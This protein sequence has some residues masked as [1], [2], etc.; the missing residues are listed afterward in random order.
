MLISWI[1]VP[2]QAGYLLDFPHTT[3]NNIDCFNCHNV[4]G[5]MEKFFNVVMPD[6]PQNLDDTPANNLCWSCHNDVVAPFMKTHSSI[7]I[8][9]DYGDWAIECRTCHEPHYHYQLAAY[10]E[11]AHLTSGVITEVTET[12]LTSAG[13][14]WQDDEFAGLV[15]LIRSV[16]GYR[17]VSNTSDTLT[18]K[19][20]VE[21]DKVSPGDNFVVIY[22]KLVRQKINTPNSGQKPV[23][24]FRPVGPNSLVDGDDVYNGPCEVCHTKTRHHRNNNNNPEQADHTHNVGIKCTLC[25]KHVNGFMPLGAGAHDI[26]LVKDFG[27][28]ITCGEGNWGCHGSYEPGSNYPNEVYFADGL[29][30]CDSRPNTACPNAGADTGTQV[31]A[32]CHGEGSLL[33]KYYFFRPGSSEGESGIKVTAYSGEYTWANTW[34]G[35]LGEQKFCGS[36]HNDS[37]NPAPVAGPGSIGDPPNIVGDLNLETGAN[38]YGFYVNGHGKP[39]DQNYGRLSWQDSGATGNPGAGRVCSDCHDYTKGHWDTGGTKRLKEGYENDTNNSV[40]VQCHGP[41][42]LADANPRWF[43][44]YATYDNSA[45]GADDKQ[46]IQCSTC[47][48]PHG[49]MDPRNP[50]AGSAATA[51]TRGNK[52]ELCFRCHSDSGDLMHV[53]NFAIDGFRGTH[54]GI[55]NQAA[56]NDA[57]GL[58]YDY[59][60]LMDDPDNKYD[61][62][63]TWTVFN[64]TDGSS[65]VIYAPDPATDRTIVTATLTGGTD[66]DWDVGDEYHIV[67]NSNDGEPMD[68]IEKAFSYPNATVPKGDYDG[69]GAQHNMG[70]AFVHD[71]KNYN[72]QC[73]SCHNVHLVTG[74]FWEADKGKSPVSKFPPVNDVPEAI[75]G[76]DPGEKMDVFAASGDGIYRPT[77]GDGFSGDQLPAYPQFCLGC[78]GQPQ[79]NHERFGI[80]WSADPSTAAGDMHGLETAGGPAGYGVCPNWYGCGKA[81]GWGLDE[82]ISESPEQE[83]WPV[84]PRGRGDEIHSRKNYN[85]EERVAGANFVLSCT[86]C[87]EAHGS[88]NVSMLRPKTNL[89]TGDYAWNTMCNNCHYY[90]SD[91]HAGMSCGQSSCHAAR[92]PHRMVN[93]FRGR[94]NNIR[95][96]DSDLVLNLSFNGNL[97][98]SSNFLLDSI[99]SMDRHNPAVSR[100]ACKGA[101]DPYACCT[102]P[103]IGTCNAECT[104]DGTPYSCCTS[105]ER[106]MCTDDNPRDVCTDYDNPDKVG[107]FVTGRFGKAIEVNDQPIEVGTENCKWSTDAGYHN[108]WVYTDM[109]YNM[110]LESWV[111]PTDDTGERKIMAKHTYWSGG[112]ALALKKINGSLRAGLLTNINGG[113]G[114]DCNGLR[115]AFSSVSIPLNQWTHVAATYDAKGPDRDDSDGSVGRVRIYVNGEDVTD[116]FNSTTQCYTQPGTGE[117]AM[118]PHSDWNAIDPT[119]CYAGHW[120][121]SALSVGG[122]NWSDLNNNFIGK[123]DEVKVW[124]VTKDDAYFAAADSQAGPYISR[125]EGAVGSNK[126]TVEFSEGVYGDIGVTSALKTDDFMLVD[127]DDSRTII[128][129][130]H[131]AGSNTAVLTLSSILDGTN[132]LDLDTLA[133]GSIYDEYDSVASTA[134]VTIVG[135]IYLPCPTSPV[136][137]DLNEARDSST[138]EDSQ[139]MLKGQVGGN[140]TLTGNAFSGDGN[141]AESNYVSFGSNYSC[142]QA[143]TAMTLETRIKP[144]GIDASDTYIKRILARDSGSANWQVSVWR[145]NTWDNYSAPANT[146]SIALWNVPVDGHGGLSWKAVLSDYDRCPITNDHWYQVKVV[147]D[148][149]KSGGIPGEFFVPA[150]IYIDDQGTDG[151]GSGENWAGYANCTNAAQS[152]NSDTQKYYTGDEMT[153]ADGDFAIGANTKNLTKQDHQFNGLIDWIIWKDTA[154]PAP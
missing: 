133:A 45:H 53:Q 141:G 109:K 81:E 42:K 76:D 147:W 78:H 24:L 97:K 31:C 116:S 152:Y 4:L 67:F 140:G 134:A 111:Y 33:A 30:L 126:L 72:L 68:N 85:H 69:G 127:N 2:A 95:T 106:G 59:K 103:G 112:Y 130:S 35:E 110:T 6:P 154:D 55:D 148:T 118:F 129:V 32:N 3:V 70:T 60:K 101:G 121:A 79:E 99:W 120:C 10:G 44:D 56:L 91:W 29:T 41:G 48:D 18:L 146:A 16:G 143:T 115:G 8:D 49:V 47:H 139:S 153:P 132:D 84:I 26:H 73:I 34:L 77:K 43:T 21:L 51:M 5:G 128:G 108:T 117:D 82:C 88:I 107:S 25:H 7:S 114:S 98:D 15:L 104:G 124:N 38:T 17:I 87:H 149:N 46:N 23:K 63:R 14:D 93:K 125:V 145:N 11:E 96:F 150:D 1:M 94:T 40:C 39:S 83:C 54:D 62:E 13:A 131:I 50:A 119:Q 22:G 138:L 12:S 71:G 66:N 135:T 123:L 74:R 144:T 80:D 9:N 100:V 105:A 151:A 19:G 92:S 122:M 28:K 65:G 64:L 102:G 86:D 137:F 113:G 36:C 52:Q 61:N 20:P 27:P 142:L 75:W 136:T 89:G 57:D 90:Y 58:Y 37:V